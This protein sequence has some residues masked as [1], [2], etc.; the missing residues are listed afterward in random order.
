MTKH[1]RRAKRK[2]VGGRIFARRKILAEFLPALRLAK[3][4]LQ[5]FRQN[6]FDFVQK[7]PPIYNFNIFESCCL[8]SLRSGS[9]EMR[10]LYGFLNQNNFCPLKRKFV[11]AKPKAKRSL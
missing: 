11:L 2:G 7:V 9:A 3:S 6:K 1:K 5:D 8:A 4:W 10:I